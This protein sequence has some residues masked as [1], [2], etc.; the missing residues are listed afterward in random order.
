MSKWLTKTVE[1]YRVD[2]KGEVDIL[3]EEAEENE[4]YN[5]VGRNIK[6]KE[7]KDDSYWIVVLT[8]EITSVKTPTTQVDVEYSA[9]GAF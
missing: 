9:G 4:C 3:I 2:T 5:L 7:T 1:T 8:K 6:Y